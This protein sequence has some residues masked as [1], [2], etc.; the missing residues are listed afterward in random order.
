MDRFFRGLIGGL[1]GAVVMNIW[2]FIS[3]YLLHFTNR[4][5]LDWAS[6]FL[7]GS[8]PNNIFE[9]FYALV[10][11]ILWTGF[12]GVILAYLIPQVSSRGSLVKG[13]FYG[14]I[15]GFFIYAIPVAFKIPYL[16]KTPFGITLSQSIGGILWGMTLAWVLKLLDERGV[17]V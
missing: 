9:S 10:A 6:I 8:L 17:E 4:R 1:A 16:Y 11:Q 15:T 5:Y 7:Y 13:A 3:F 2:D 14:F 12:L